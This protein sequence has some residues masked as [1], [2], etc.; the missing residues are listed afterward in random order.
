MP[1]STTE[2]R[3]QNGETP[4]HEAVMAGNLDEMKKLIAQGADVNALYID[5]ANA[6]EG[7]ALLLAVKNEDL[8]AV[9]Y[10]IDI[11]ADITAT[12]ANGLSALHLAVVADQ[13]DIVAVLL[14]EGADVRKTDSSGRTAL[15]WASLA[16]DDRELALL[17]L[18]HGAGVNALNLVGESPLHEAVTFGNVDAVRVLL[19]RG[20]DRN[21]KAEDGTTA[22]ARARAE[23]HDAIVELLQ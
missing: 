23:G 14:I 21:L 2:T 10:L 4:F 18:K 6:D 17:L 22:L 5:E 3:N 12:D 9:A 19:E 8:E 20:A 11:G 16:T 7:T 15:H 13:K 1:S